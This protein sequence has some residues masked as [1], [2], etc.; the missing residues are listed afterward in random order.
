MDPQSTSNLDTRISLPNASTPKEHVQVEEVC[1]H[2]LQAT[3][4]HIGMLWAEKRLSVA[5]EHF[6]TN[7][8]RTRL[9]HIFDT[10]PNKQEG[11]IIFIGCAPQEPHEIGALMLAL[12]WRR[13][14]LNIVYLGQMVE[15]HSLLQEVVQRRPWVVCL[16]AMTRPR[17]PVK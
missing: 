11:V 13:I 8:I 7:I 5:V 15:I 3:L 17:A 12:F 1:L 9:T 4:F 14:G 16:S 2:L 6:A 10:T